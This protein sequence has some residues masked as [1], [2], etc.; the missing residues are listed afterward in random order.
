MLIPHDPDY[1]PQE[2]AAEIAGIIRMWPRR[3]YQG[4]WFQA[5][6][7]VYH[8]R[9]EL[10]AASL[11]EDNA[12]CGSTACVAGWAAILTSPKGTLIGADLLSP[13]GGLQAQHIHDAGRH[14]LGL[15]EED[16][17]WLFY[18]TRSREQ[19]LAALDSLAKGEQMT[20]LAD[21]Y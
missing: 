7:E 19:V 1:D 3:W 17:A 5:R 11:S 13:P 15:S 18:G 6:Y 4:S 12:A 10:V 2:V 21:D 9:V 20:R 16:A 8:R 14:A